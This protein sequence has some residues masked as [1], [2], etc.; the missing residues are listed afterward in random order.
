MEK[1]ELLSQKLYYLTIDGQNPFMMNNEFI[2]LYSDVAKAD[3]TK[4]KFTERFARQID[5]TEITDNAEF[6]KKM[7]SFGF[8][9]FIFNG[10]SSVYK[11][12]DFHDGT[13]IIR[14]IQN[15]SGPTP[16]NNIPIK[17]NVQHK[18]KDNNAL[19]SM[20]CGIASFVF[21][22][23][24]VSVVAVVFGILSMKNSKRVGV[25]SDGRA[26]AGTVLGAINIGWTLV[27]I[28]FAIILAIKG[29]L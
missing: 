23:P 4:A 15:A 25:K 16:V 17:P 14:H 6:I 28:G 20:I 18:P 13:E 27:G 9:K 22:I 10:D 7:I 11:F 24:F 5:K 26:V 29:S 2:L 1:Q 12:S 21:P 3:A 19:V 8:E